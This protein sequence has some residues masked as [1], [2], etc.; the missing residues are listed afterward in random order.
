MPGSDSGTD[1]WREQ[2]WHSLGSAL[3]PGSNQP[4]CVYEDLRAQ[5]TAYE[6]KTRTTLASAGAEPIGDQPR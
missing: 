4:L 5:P 6:R 3:V 1:R 2:H